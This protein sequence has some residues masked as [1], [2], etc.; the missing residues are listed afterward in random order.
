M[1]LAISRKNI[2]TGEKVI[3]KIA[4]AVDL[5]KQWVREVKNGNTDLSF[6]DWLDDEELEDEV[7][8]T[9]KKGQIIFNI[10][11]SRK[12][13]DFSSDVQLPEWVNVIGALQMLDI[14]LTAGLT[15]EINGKPSS[16]GMIINDGDKV[17]IS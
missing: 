10:E 6:E 12:S 11:K 7:E 2:E 4:G 1:I 14:P 15:I 13:V 16:F 3:K 5:R 9:K 8:L 17:V